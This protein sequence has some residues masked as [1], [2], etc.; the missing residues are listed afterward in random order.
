MKHKKLAPTENPPKDSESG[1]T[2]GPSNREQE[3]RPPKKRPVPQ[4]TPEQ[5][6]DFRELQN[7]IQKAERGK[8]AASEQRALKTLSQIVSA[9]L[10]SSVTEAPRD[11]L[12]RGPARTHPLQ[13]ELRRHRRPRHPNPCQRRED[14]SNPS[15]QTDQKWTN[16]GIADASTLE[17]GACV[18]PKLFQPTNPYEIS[19]AI[20]QAEAA[21]ETIRALGS[22]WSFS[23]AVLPQQTAV[24]FTA[25][26]IIGLLTGNPSFAKF[27]G[28]AIQPTG[29]TASLQY[30]L[31]SILLRSVDVESLFFVEAGIQLTS[32]NDLLNSQ[33]P[34]L[35]FKT[36]GGCIGQTLAGAISTGTHGSDFDRPPLADNVR[37]IYLIGAGGAHHWI[38]AASSQITDPV[39]VRATF[40]CISAANC[41]Y[42]D[43]MFRA[44]LVSMGSMGVIY[45]LVIDVVP[46]Y[47]LVQFNLWSV[48]ET[49]QTLEVGGINFE[50]VVLGQLFPKLQEFF[51]VF[52]IQQFAKSRALQIVVNPIKNDDGTH[53]CYATVRFE[54]PLQDLPAGISLPFGVTPGNLSTLTLSD[55]KNAI[56]NSP[57]CGL[58]QQVAFAFANI[59]GNTLLEQAQSLIN[60]CKSYNYFWAVRAVIDLLMQET[61][62]LSSN[63]FLPIPFPQMDLGYKVM[64]GNPFG[65]AFSLLQVTSM[66]AGFLFHDAISYVNSLLETFDAGI[67]QN[68]FPAGYVSLRACGP[69]A[70]LL[71]M[72]QFGSIGAD[73]FPDVTGMVEISLLGNSDDFGVIRQAEQLALSQG[74]LLHWGQSNGLMTA[75]DVQERYPN[76]AKWMA[77]QRI[78]GSATF[79]NLFMRRCA[80]A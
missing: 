42:D 69:T 66:E 65:T 60:F 34:P 50:R 7:E 80:L 58:A 29:F 52:D 18:V 26:N 5:L 1:R 33:S 51:D 9:E 40:P 76:V 24:P 56:L 20:N 17:I 59:S 64:S 72:E 78:L 41:H 57:D 22:G 37:A 43:D 27:F 10:L 11:G 49:L 70:A 46:Q 39:K 63:P 28:F 25:Q 12:S 79:T 54:I 44:A 53:N 74:A 73:A 13:Q 48:W 30:L 6:V 38:E 55:I 77:A 32:L 3:P 19:S 75:F 23:D 16:W 14:A 15:E 47:A 67:P 62:P 21:G 71:G 4:L 8:P 68:I 61:Y 35:A 36:L 2:A 31:P 45:A